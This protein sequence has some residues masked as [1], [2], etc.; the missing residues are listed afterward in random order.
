[1]RQGEEQTR[2]NDLQRDRLSKLSE[3]IL[4]INESL[5][6]ETVL[7]DVLDSARSLTDAM[8]GVITLVDGKNTVERLLSSGFTPEETGRLW[9]WPGGPELFDYLGTIS[10][11]LRLPDF[12]SHTQE[13][14][15]PE[16]R[17]PMSE[18]PSFSFLAAPIHHRGEGVGHFFLAAKEGRREFSQ[19]DEEILVMFASQAALVIAN[20]RRRR[21]EQRAKKNLETLIHMSP[22]GIVVFDARTG[23]PVSFNREAARIVGYLSAPG[24]SPEELLKLLTVRRADGREFSLREFPLAQA[25]SSGETVRAEEIVL[26]A[27]DGRSITTLMN[28]TPIHSEED[29]EL[30]SVVVTLQDLT[31]LED[32]ERLR[33][34]FLAKVSHEL[35]APLSTIKG[36]STTL[37]QALSDLDPAEMH[38]FHRIIDEQADYMR[39]LVSDLLDVARI[40]TGALPVAPEPSELARLVDEARAKLQS[41][42]GNSKLRIELA[43]DLPL[44]MADRRRIVQVLNN[45]LSNAA[46]FS[47]ES[48]AISVSAVQDG[49]H[50]AVTVADEG[51][52][53]SSARLQYIFSKFP[54][55]DL[56]EGGRG[57]EGSGLGL[58]IS[59]GIVEAH[60]G[61]IWAESDGPGLG[62]RFTFTLPA[63]ESTAIPLSAE[64]S[65][66]SAGTS[67]TESEP[68]RVLVV[69]DDPQTLRYVGDALAKADYAPL[70]TGDPR[71]ALRLM[72][73]KHP[74]LVLLD[75]MLPGTDG[76]ELM[77]EMLKIADVPVI[78]LS[79]YRQDE[80]IARALD[81]GAVD[82]V[83]KPFSPTELIARVRAALRRR[84][85]PE[86]VEPYV[87]GPL[88]VDHARHSVTV[89]GRPIPLTAIEY[90]LLFELSARAGQI[91]TYEHLLNRIWNMNKTGDL[92]PMRTVVRNLRQK[93]G[94]EAK[95]PVY[96]FNEPRVGYRMAKPDKQIE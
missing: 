88:V 44:V 72:E 87:L 51:K 50:V 12:V 4:R 25:L 17:L 69:D 55:T 41:G 52:G 70:V 85:T 75:L 9:D 18:S 64:P 71:E 26:E 16:L 46:R 80:I 63:A 43:P 77:A 11:P 93:L 8:Y 78:F 10:R 48:S 56:E 79:V 67:R 3:A 86:L 20:A 39:D 42:G 81:T 54:P 60:G 34:D 30:D 49:I 58:A 74:D 66:R 90:R 59:K 28:A 47:R 68:R 22:V 45:L 29:G 31:P 33:A 91:L 57:A 2:A 27:P 62:T 21:D 37:L 95:Q 1:M 5:E 61:R 14:N 13:L 82:Y 76:I 36:S 65:P 83:V 15:L 35:R 94:D 40:E 6:F 84:A 24:S 96:L 53:L 19:D 23:D 7:Q 38:Q 89:A 92:R 73:E 32:L